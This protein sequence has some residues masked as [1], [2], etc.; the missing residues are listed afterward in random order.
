MSYAPFE[1]SAGSLRIGAVDFVSL[2]TKSRSLLDIEAPETRN[3][4]AG[5]PTAIP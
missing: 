3:P 4:N 1:P 2:P 5:R